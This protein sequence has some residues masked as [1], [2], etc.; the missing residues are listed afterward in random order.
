M[1]KQRR[2]EQNEEFRFGITRLDP[3]EEISDV[4]FINNS[5]INA[6]T[7]KS[8]RYTVKYDFTYVLNKL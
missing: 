4:V 1:S 6:L 2:F 8:E 3:I 7:P 5:L